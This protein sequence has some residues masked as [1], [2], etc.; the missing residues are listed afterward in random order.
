MDTIKEICMNQRLLKSLLNAE[1]MRKGAARRGT[2]G[3]VL[4]AEARPAL[5]HCGAGGACSLGTCKRCCTGAKHVG[6]CSVKA[7]RR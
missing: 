2:E 1:V 4:D 6:G 7:C 5:L 3:S